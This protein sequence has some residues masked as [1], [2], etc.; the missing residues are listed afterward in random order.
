MK[1]I[2]TKTQ[3]DYSMA[4]ANLIAQMELMREQLAELRDNSKKYTNL[5]PNNNTETLDR[6][7]KQ[8]RV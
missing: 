4:V 5:Y 2:D 8:C 1:I 3:F 6:V 7:K